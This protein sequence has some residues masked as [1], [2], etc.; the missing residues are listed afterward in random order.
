MFLILRDRIIVGKTVLAD[1]TKT[2]FV[3]HKGVSAQFIT[4]TAFPSY[5]FL[6]ALLNIHNLCN[7]AVY[8]FFLL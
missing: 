3:S 6:D 7:T 1:N 2:A 5:M 4:S 8:F